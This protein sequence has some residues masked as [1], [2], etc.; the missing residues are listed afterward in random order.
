MSRFSTARNDYNWKF[1]ADIH[2]SR[3]CSLAAR[4]DV[5]SLEPFAGVDASEPRYTAGG[6]SKLVPQ[7]LHGSQVSNL[8]S[9]FSMYM[10]N[11]RNLYGIRKSRKRMPGQSS[12]IVKCSE[13]HLASML[14]SGSSDF[15]PTVTLHLC[16]CLRMKLTCASRNLSANEATV[17]SH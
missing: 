12:S 16:H 3:E 11:L 6:S 8:L 15:A 5:P 1:H 13:T 10:M 14:R 2:V 17:Q 7:T 9:F 4:P